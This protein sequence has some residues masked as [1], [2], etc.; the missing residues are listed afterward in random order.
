MLHNFF[1]SHTALIVK[2]LLII[3]LGFDLVGGCYFVPNTF[4]KVPGVQP[5]RPPGR[6]PG[7]PPQCRPSQDPGRAGECRTQDIVKGWSCGP[8][9][10]G[11]LLK[12]KGRGPCSVAAYLRIAAI[13][14]GSRLS[15]FGCAST[16]R[17]MS[18]RSFCLLLF[19]RL[20][21]RY[22]RTLPARTSSRQAT[23]I[24]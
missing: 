4:P 8:V 14:P 7:P 3:H 12:H 9:E 13:S 22:A 5:E 21:S 6:Y 16:R 24:S 1:L 19:L 10:G 11:Q 17:R 15:S 18:A 20:S 23:A 2:H